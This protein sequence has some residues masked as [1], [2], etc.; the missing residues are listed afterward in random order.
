MSPHD[1]TLL[2]NLA[3]EFAEQGCRVHYYARESRLRT[4][5]EWR[6]LNKLGSRFY[7]RSHH[8]GEGSKDK[9]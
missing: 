5:D 4:E 3:S 9:S 1:L 7:I 2:L 6:L 8:G